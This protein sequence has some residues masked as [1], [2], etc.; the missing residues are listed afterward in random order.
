MIILGIKADGMKY[1]RKNTYSV[2]GYKQ[3]IWHWKS[4]IAVALIQ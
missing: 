1:L 4:L 3:K 2:S